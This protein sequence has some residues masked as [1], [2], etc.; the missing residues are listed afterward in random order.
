MKYSYSGAFW[1]LIVVS[2]TLA[3]VSCTDPWT[4][5]GGDA[6][7]TIAVGGTGARLAV[8]GEHTRALLE[9]EVSFTG[10]QKQPPL[11]LEVGEL[12]KTVKLTEGTWVIEVKA[13]LPDAAGNILVGTGLARD[14]KLTA[15]ANPPLSI[16]MLF[17]NAELRK[18]RVTLGRHT[19]TAAK[20]ETGYTLWLPDLKGV[21]TLMVLEA[22]P[23]V[24]DAEV[25]IGNEPAGDGTATRIIALAG[26]ETVL[27]PL[28]IQVAAGEGQAATHTLQVTFSDPGQ[29]PDPDDTT[30]GVDSDFT[31]DLGSTWADVDLTLQADYLDDLMWEFQVTP[32]R[33]GATYTWFLDGELLHASPERVEIMANGRMLGLLVLD[34]KLGQHEIMVRISETLG[35]ETVYWSKSVLFNVD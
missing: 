18:L 3:P 34:L 12:S 11:T 24:P 30:G 4:A 29:E 22:I 35:N 33:A 6:V 2:L 21:S 10:P 19:Y 28:A 20:T 14:V 26:T 32:P 15:G 23:A 27:P 16:L 1:C 25:R 17:T 31:L 8:P 7:L 13:Y 5:S 9:Y